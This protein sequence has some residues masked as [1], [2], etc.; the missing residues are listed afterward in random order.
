MSPT[1]PRDRSAQ[2]LAGVPLLRAL[3][4][5]LLVQLGAGVVQRR[6]SAGEEI[7]RRGDPGDRLFLVVEGEVEIY[8][9]EEPRREVVVLR[10]LAVGDHFGELALIDGG[11]R[12]ASARAVGPT[13]LVSLGQEAFLATTLAS[14]EAAHLVLRELVTRLRDTT[15]ILAQ[16]ASRDVVRER[17]AQLTPGER[18]ANLVARWNGSWSFV[19]AVVLLSGGWM[20]WNLL[21]RAAFDPYPFVFF[22]LL[23]AILVVLQGPLLMM[24]QNRES[25][26][27]RARA[28]VDFRV[29]LKNEVAIER[30]GQDLDRVRRELA[31]LRGQPAGEVAGDRPPA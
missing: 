22:N 7:F 23:L 21:A 20:A 29:N 2:L 26:Q 31:A 16:R 24:S 18:F 15:A 17:D 11:T 12:T 19:A 30:I 5:E 4:E 25:E 3:P 1:P 10:H 6:C 27:E 14:P 13:L 9:P 8:L 28:E